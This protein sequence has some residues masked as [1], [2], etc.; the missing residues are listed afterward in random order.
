MDTHVYKAHVDSIYDGDTITCTIDCGFGLSMIKQK[1]RLYGINC[2]EMRGSKKEDGRNA[3]DVLRSKILN[4]DILLR[5]I[6][7][8]KGRYF[9]IIYISDSDSDSVNMNNWLVENDFAVIANN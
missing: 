1:I 6:K 9:G 2:P 5:T 8:K 4:K 7:D 3:R